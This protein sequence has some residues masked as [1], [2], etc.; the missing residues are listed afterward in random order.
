MNVKILVQCLAPPK[1]WKMTAVNTTIIIIFQITCSYL[2]NSFPVSMFFSISKYMYSRVFFYVL[3]GFKVRFK[4]FSN[5]KKYF[6]F[7]ILETEVWIQ[8]LV[9]NWLN[10]W[11]WPCKAISYPL[12]TDNKIISLPHRECVFKKIIP[13]L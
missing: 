7:L 6:F 10:L 1:C 9:Y 11:T 5:L 3:N 13:K 12:N 2:V 8:T 4:V